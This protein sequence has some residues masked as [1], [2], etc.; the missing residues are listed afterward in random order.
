[1]R[2]AIIGNPG[3]PDL[4]NAVRALLEILDERGVPV[5]LY[6]GMREELSGV[7][8]GRTFGAYPEIRASATYAIAFGGDGTMLGASR[9]LAGSGIPLVGVNLGKLG[10]LA[11]FSVASLAR[12]I[13]DLLAGRCRIVERALLQA[14]FPDLSEQEPIIA[15][16]DIVFDKRGAGLMM[17]METFINGDFLGA[18]RADGLILSTPTGST[19][20][21]LAVGGPVVVPSAQVIVMAPIAPHMLT[22]RPVVVPDTAVIEV[23]P[24]AQHEGETATIIADGQLYRNLPMPLR[25]CITRHHDTAALVKS[26][27]T[28]YFDVLRA[29]LL[30]GEEVRTARHEAKKNQP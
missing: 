9:M 12:T 30:W 6:E 8:S 3:K 17:Q 5:L 16:N 29:K 24:I 20:Y 4:P 2:I 10:F 18:Y 15:L 25:V 26:S 1:M 14:T 22:A 23:C 7:A 21:S 27:A 28:T 13:D 19:A 11:E